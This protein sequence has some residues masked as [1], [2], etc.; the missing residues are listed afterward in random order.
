MSVQPGIEILNLINAIERRTTARMQRLLREAGVGL[1]AMEARTLRFVARHPGCTQSDIVRAS[2]R[3]KAQIARIIKILRERDFIGPP[4]G[5]GRRPQP[6]ALTA[7]GTAIHSHAE[8]LRA[9]TA[10][11]LVA[12][13]GPDERSQL[14]ALLGRLSPLESADQD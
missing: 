7:T 4:A 3:D 14:E 1:A 8:S 10:R 13:L 9:D 5:G 6:L 2:G 11:E 12:G